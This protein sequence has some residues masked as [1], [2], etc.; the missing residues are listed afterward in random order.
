MN[1][2]LHL[3]GEA[4]ANYPVT[5]KS[6]EFIGQSANTVC[7]ITDMQGNRY[8]LRLH[9]SVSEGLESYWS[10]PN[11]VRSEMVWLHALERDTDL[12][13]PSPI[14]NHDGDFVTIT[15]GT[16]STL[17]K[18]VDGEQKEHAASVEEAEAMGAMIGKLHRHSANWTVPD[19]FERPAFDGSRI[20][21]TIDN[22]QQ[23]L[24]R[25]LLPAA[26]TD[27]LQRA[28]R[29]VVG[30]MKAMPRTS[31]N[32]GI[33]HADLNPG[34]IVFHGTE[35]RPI[36][37]GACGFGFYL[38]DLGWALCHIHPAYRAHLL[39][40]YANYYPLPDD[41]VEQ[42]EGFYIAAQL[43]TM[44]FWLGLPD[45]REWLPDHIRNLARREVTAYLNREPFLFS[46]I[47]YW[48]SG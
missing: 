30:M 42:L 47:P 33:I 27:L 16:A 26:D 10:K 23:Q 29:R 40:A 41:H 35:A 43:D 48:E 22:L 11:V 32:W 28:G 46:G 12:T 3:A 8:A 19:G 45:W 7:K 34:N 31:A 4:L 5:G 38:F 20:L 18:W 2:H 21:Q 24:D 39:R 37:F 15:D 14:R 25:G 44:Y 36:D 6:I 13:V 9:L 1:D 17:L